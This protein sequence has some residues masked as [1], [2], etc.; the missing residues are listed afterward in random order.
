MKLPMDIILYKIIQQYRLKDLSHQ[1][2]V[3]MEIQKF[4]YGP[5]QS[6]NTSNDRLKQNLENAYT[7]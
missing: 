1:G 3:Y 2:F 6:F 7:R 4:M 5:P